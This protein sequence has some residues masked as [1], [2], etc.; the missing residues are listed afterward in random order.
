MQHVYG[1]GGYL[2]N[3]CADHAAALGTFW[4]SSLATVSL[5]VGFGTTLVRHL[6]DFSTFQQTL[7]HFTRTEFSIDT[8]HRVLCVQC[9]P[10]VCSCH[11]QPFVSAFSGSLL[12]Q[13][14]MD[15]LSSS[16]SAASSINDCSEHNM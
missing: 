1:H 12:S 14:V 16:A 15:R 2:G 6:N 7:L 3:E 8:S 4:A 5:R 13:Q 11:V 10:Y 9:A